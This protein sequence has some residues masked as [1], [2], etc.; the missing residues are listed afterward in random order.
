MTQGIFVRILIM[1][2]KP[3]TILILLLLA[4]LTQAGVSYAQDIE[5]LEEAAITSAIA[6]V[7][8]SVLQIE[9]IGGLDRV[10]G[11]AVSVGPCSA[12]VIHEDGYLIASSFSFIHRPA[13]IFVKLPSG[14]RAACQIVARDLSRNLLLLKVDTE[15]KLSVPE[16]V[17]RK[18]LEVG[19][20]AIA[21]GR[22]F[23]PSATNISTGIIS[24]TNRIWGK[25]VQADA[26]ISPNNFGG[27][28]INI[29]GKVIG[30]LTPLSTRGET[31]SAGI[32]WYDSGIGFAVPFEGLMERLDE[33]KKG[34]SLYAGKIG[35]SF[36]G[37]NVYADKAEV[38]ALVGTSP[39]AKAGIRAGDVIVELAGKKIRRQSELRHAIGPFYANDTIKVVVQRDGKPL[40]F[41]VT[42]AQKIDPYVQTYL[43]MMLD[44]S[45]PQ[46][47]NVVRH[48]FAGSPAAKA[49]VQAGDSI[50]KL[51]DVPV[52]DIE[53]IRGLLFDVK[54]SDAVALGIVRNGK[55][56]TL[57][58]AAAKVDASIPKNLKPLKSIQREPQTTTGIVEVKVPE[59]PNLCHAFVP[60][61]QFGSAPGLMVWI[62]KPGE[63]DFESYSKRW[64]QVCNEWNLILL[65]PQSADKTKWVPDDADFIQKAV[66]Q[67]KL[68]HPF[69]NNRTAI[70][71]SASGGS[72]AALTAFGNR[73]VFRGLILVDAAIPTR[74]GRLSADPVNRLHV[75]LPTYAE[76]DKDKNGKSN[77][78]KLN[79]AKIPVSHER[80]VP[81]DLIKDSAK[82]LNGLDRF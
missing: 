38:A 62:A 55:A 47:L 26:K 18:D 61:S 16:F 10:D 17:S 7:D 19:G 79:A 21:V 45:D 23:D 20:W 32:D 74:A 59:E 78:G 49:G 5:Q 69:D 46:K 15:E 40:E 64:Q 50:E 36:K 68:T 53:T 43:G 66:D 29:D 22:V 11:N 28:L 56:Q 9:T 39:A 12:T 33:W 1:N 2:L 58:F 14:E 42:L 25:A 54:V 70:G 52:K 27:P 77:L 63:V 71:G 73:D 75:L 6:K 57:S 4:G 31:V 67:L 60:T 76:L 80:V 41:S 48:V 65:V 51:N 37:S 3:I 8:A 81:A 30:I 34:T 13:S 44:N 82:W 35:V 24:A 72:M